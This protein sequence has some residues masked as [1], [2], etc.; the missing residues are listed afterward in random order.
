[1]SEPGISSCYLGATILM[2]LA[3]TLWGL[4]LWHKPASLHPNSLMYRYIYYRFFA[5][6]HRQEELSGGLTEKQ[7][8][9]YAITAVVIGVFMVMTGLVVMLGS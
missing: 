7:I 8:R 1:M 6:R 9:I 3:I 4:R 5:W 2:G